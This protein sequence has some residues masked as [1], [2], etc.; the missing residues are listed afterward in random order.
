MCQLLSPALCCWVACMS[1]GGGVGK[2]LNLQVGHWPGWAES[3]SSPVRW[4]QGAGQGTLLSPGPFSP[5][6]L[7]GDAGVSFSSA[8]LPAWECCRRS[9]PSSKSVGTRS[10]PCTG[11]GHGGLGGPEPP[12]ACHGLLG[13]SCPSPPASGPGEEQTVGSPETSPAG[14]WEQQGLCCN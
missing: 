11:P 1:T 3:V 5:E 2:D 12:R 14:T 10:W 6:K 9:C 13:A 4:A 7:H 8:L